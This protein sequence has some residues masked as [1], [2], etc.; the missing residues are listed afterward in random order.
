MEQIKRELAAEPPAEVSEDRFGPAAY[1]LT[2][3]DIAFR[4]LD[5]TPELAPE[6]KRLTEEGVPCGVGPG[7]AAI[8]IPRSLLIAAGWNPPA[9]GPTSPT[10]P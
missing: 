4:S 7:E 6:F 5:Q 8:I 9:E 10:Q 2:S 3:G 1:L